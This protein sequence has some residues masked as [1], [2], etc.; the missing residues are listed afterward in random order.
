MH[1]E[2]HR[3]FAIIFLK[4][5]KLGFTL[6]ELLVVITIIGLLASVGLASFTRAQARARD[7]KRQSDITSVR[8]ALEIFY[9]ENNV[10]PDT[11]GG[12]QNIETILDT[13]I[14]TFIKVLPAD[15][16]GEGLPYRY[17]SV[18]NQGYCLGGK[19]ET[20]TATSTTCT[21]SLETNYNYGLGNP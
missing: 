9:A 18:T 13:L 6:L 7:A 21:V 4:M 8:T 11:G 16:G 15:P 20:A 10:Y 17:R 5:K 2:A 19:L 3:P 1:S 12:W 14:P